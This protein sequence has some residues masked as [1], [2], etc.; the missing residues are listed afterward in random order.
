MVALDQIV[1]SASRTAVTRRKSPGL[2]QVMTSELIEQAQAVSLADALPFQPGVRVE[3][4]CQNCGF[5]QVRI[6]GLDGNYSQILMDSRPVFSALAG[7]YGLEHIPANMIDRIEVLRG[8]GSA[9]YGSSAVEG[10]SMSLHAILYL[11]AQRL[12]TPLL[13][14]VWVRLGITILRLTLR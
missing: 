6:N 13:P 3:N 14:L 9:L 7:V 11:T 2:V 1:V 5:S 4:N 8:G 10:L 12:L